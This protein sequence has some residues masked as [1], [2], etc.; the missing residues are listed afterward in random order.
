MSAS[1]HSEGE[2][3]QAY[4]PDSGTAKG[5]QISERETLFDHRYIRIEEATFTTPDR[6]DPV[7]WTIARRKSGVVVAPRLADGRFLLILQERYP[8]ERTLWEFPAGQIDDLENQDDEQTVRATGL[9]ELQEECGHCLAEGAEL[10]SLGYFFSSHGFTDEHA[11]LFLATAVEPH[12]AGYA[13]DDAENILE[14]RAFSLDELR[15]MIAANEIVDAN[16]LAIFARLTAR[17]LV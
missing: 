10:L 4:Q 16:T 9:R 13:P 8:V 12:S 7:R 11:Y 17:E 5:W 2:A 3:F 14:T 15:T 1:D 6:S